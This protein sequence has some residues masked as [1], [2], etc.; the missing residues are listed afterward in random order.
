LTALD[1]II[2]ND[3]IFHEKSIRSHSFTSN[4]CTA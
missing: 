2:D 4:K 1:G 3:P